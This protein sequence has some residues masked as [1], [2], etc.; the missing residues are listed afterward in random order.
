MDILL[1]K[2]LHF[3]QNRQVILS[4]LLSL[5]D[6][7]Q[8]S[9]VLSFSPVYSFTRSYCSMC[10]VLFTALGWVNI[11][12]EPSVWE[13]NWR[14]ASALPDVLAGRKKDLSLGLP[15]FFVLSWVDKLKEVLRSD[16]TLSS[17]YIIV[18]ISPDCKACVV[19]CDLDG[20]FY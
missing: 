11:L 10:L 2:H 1:P 8:S 20:D 18:Q 15:L 5:G 7:W 17:L 19:H 13:K 4:E 6:Y 3:L 12:L 9:C 16:G 14:K